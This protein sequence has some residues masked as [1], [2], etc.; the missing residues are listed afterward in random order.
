MNSPYYFYLILLQM[1]KCAFFLLEGDR[2]IV[3][4][5]RIF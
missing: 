4:Y 5:P 3:S 1:D 2:A